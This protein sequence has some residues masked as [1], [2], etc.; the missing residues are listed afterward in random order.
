[1]TSYTD[2]DGNTATYEYD[3]DERPTKV[4]DGKGT[5]TYKY[6]LTTGFLAELVDSAAGTFTATM[7]SK[8][9]HAD[10]DLPER[11]GRPT[12]V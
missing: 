5:Q 12:T 11:Y 8:G 4:N 2:A 6:N 3:I 10:R 1:L 7:T 9:K